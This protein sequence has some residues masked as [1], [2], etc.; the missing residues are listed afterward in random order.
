MEE[1]L[2]N[3]VI[4]LLARILLSAIFIMAGGQKLGDIAGTAD[5]IASGDL[6][7]PTALA[8]LSGLFEI[9]A[10]LSI[11][12]GFQTRL[13]AYGLAAFCVALAFIFH[14]SAVNIPDFPAGANA[15]LTVTNQIMMFKNFAIAGGFLALSIAGPGAWS[16]DA[17]RK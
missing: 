8:W 15:M 7:A 16:I 3:N 4:L 6:P 10:G 2:A 13:A 17:W 9:V 12:T 1:M 14:T 11:L 5:Y